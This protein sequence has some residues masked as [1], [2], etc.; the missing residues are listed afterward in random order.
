M[1]NARD[2]SLYDRF[3]QGTTDVSAVPPQDY[4]D[5]LANDVMPVAPAGC[6]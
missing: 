5:M 4:A 1:I 3:L 6:N 2:G